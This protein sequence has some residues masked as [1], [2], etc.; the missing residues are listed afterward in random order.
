M[1]GVWQ[2][3][4]VRLPADLHAEVKERARQEERTMAQT[5]RPRPPPVPPGDRAMSL[6]EQDLRQLPLVP[7]LG[8]GVPAF[9]N[10]PQ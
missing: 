10:E 5:I 8:M 3:M 9:W 4:Y 7:G 2:A 1:S 6:Y